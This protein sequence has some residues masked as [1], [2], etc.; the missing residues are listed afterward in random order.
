MNLPA[1]L[2]A[3]L[4]IGGLFAWTDSI[5]LTSFARDESPPTFRTFNLN[6]EFKFKD[7]LDNFSPSLAITGFDSPV[8]W[9]LSIY[10]F[11]FITVQSAGILSP[12]K[13][14]ISCPGFKDC[15]LIDLIWLS[16]I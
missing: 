1:I 14:W 3:I 6:V 15:T 11:P 9:E 2:S 4:C 5:R 10:E 16:P 8:I 7:P 12:A 13:T